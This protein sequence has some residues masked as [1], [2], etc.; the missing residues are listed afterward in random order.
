MANEFYE[1]LNY[2]LAQY[3]SEWSPSYYQ[4]TKDFLFS[5]FKTESKRVGNG[6][7]ITIGIDYE[8][9]DNYENATGFQVV[10]W[11]NT[12][13][14]H[15]GYNASGEGAHTEVW[16]DAVETTITSGQLLADCIVFLRGKGYNIIT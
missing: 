16:N 4:R 14:I 13:G 10:S 9:L 6:Y 1:T 5:A 2:F 3:Y 11:A 15:G 7:Q 12:R 8:S